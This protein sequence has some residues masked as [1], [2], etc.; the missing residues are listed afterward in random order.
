MIVPEPY[1]RMKNCILQLT[2][3]LNGNRDLPFSLSP[4]L[5]FV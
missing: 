2:T 3:V 5:S 1:S 4:F